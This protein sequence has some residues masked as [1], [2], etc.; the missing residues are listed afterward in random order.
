MQLPHVAGDHCDEFSDLQPLPR[1][2]W[3][4]A[5]CPTNE[6]HGEFIHKS[7]ELPS[8]FFPFLLLEMSL[9]PLGIKTKKD[10][11]P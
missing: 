4:S 8:S 9:Q 10:F 7:K 3:C 2:A 1:T 6:L 11:E 5:K